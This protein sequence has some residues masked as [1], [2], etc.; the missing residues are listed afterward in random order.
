M[1]LYFTELGIRLSFGKTSEF[2]G[3]PPPRYATVSHHTIPTQLATLQTII[4][5]NNSKK[6][7]QEVQFMLFAGPLSTRQCATD[8]QTMT[9]AVTA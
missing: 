6:H 7:L 4:D 2:R 9:S 1:D 3:P 5:I 8:T